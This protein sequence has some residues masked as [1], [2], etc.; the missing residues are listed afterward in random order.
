MNV[1]S[2]ESAEAVST[3]GVH[4]E[5][6]VR[7]EELLKGLDTDRYIQTSDIRYGSWSIESGLKRGPI[8]PSDDFKRMEEMGAVVYKSLL[9]LHLQVP[10]PF[11]DIYEFWLLDRQNMP[12]ALL[13]STCNIQEIDADKPVLWRSGKLCEKSFFPNIDLDTESSPAQ[14]LA[15]YINTLSGE[16]PRAQWFARESDGSGM[17]LAA[18]N[19]DI[20][21]E[22]ILPGAN[23][24]AYFLKTSGHHTP[25][26]ELSSAYVDWQAPWLL[27]LHELNR[28]T[29]A[30][31]EQL[32]RKQAML[33]DTQHRLYPEIV[34]SAA[35]N[36]ARVEA[37]MRRSQPEKI[38]EEKIMST[39]YLELGETER[40]K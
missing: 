8:Y 25:F 30:H 15:T 7:N 14:S 33:V 13:D 29:R 27:L 23:F 36:A 17:G 37:M 18:V 32:A 9:T 35:I 6:Y 21:E 10:F 3:D 12:L 39:W 11:A 34:D 4:W 19:L 1:I 2:Y 26:S 38:T 28:D 5:I 40:G 16:P 24:P 20:D 31:F 22:R